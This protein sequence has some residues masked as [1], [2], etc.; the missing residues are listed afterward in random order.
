MIGSMLAHHEAILLLQA[1]GYMSLSG[2]AA[3]IAA[4]WYSLTRR[5]RRTTKTAPNV[6]TPGES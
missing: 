5:T 2:F 6:H 3:V 1:G 4:R